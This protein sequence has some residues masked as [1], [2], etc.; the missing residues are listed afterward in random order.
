MGS[1][2]GGL[3]SVTQSPIVQASPAYQ[4]GSIL[5]GGSLG[6]ALGPM[7]GQSGG[8]GGT[9]LP[10]PQAAQIQPGV[11]PDQLGQGYVGAQQGLNAQQNLLQA[12]QAQNGIGNQSSVFNQSQ[13]LAN[14]LSGA[15]PV[16]T[17]QALMGQY[18]NIAAGG[19]PN[20]A[21]AML[22]QQTGQNVAN[23]GALMAGQRGA[24]ANVGLMARQAA[25]QG[26]STQ[27]Q[28]VGQAAQMQAQQQLAAM[29]AMSGLSGQQLS[30]LQAQ[31]GA[32]AGQAAGQV[33]NLAGATTGYSQGQQAEQQNLLN[34][35]AAQ[36][37]AQVG[38]Q[39]NVNSNNAQIS[40]QYIGQQGKILGGVANAVSGAA[41]LAEGG[42]VGDSDSGTDATPP[43]PMVTP[44]SPVIGSQS[45]FGRFLQGWN[46]APTG[47]PAPMAS[48]G[49]ANGGGHVSPKKSAQ[50]AEKSG[51]SYDNDKIPAMLSE[52]E[53]VLPR[54]VTQSGN[55]SESA[56]RFVQ[57][58]MAKK[59]KR[60]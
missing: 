48:G 24:G 18:A 47:T 25:Q 5:G 30:A 20:P 14:Q 36:N 3:G 4:I 34:A 52:G 21:M 15:N 38:S 55:P 31:Q 33:N 23:Q 45:S 29:Q 27:Q 42:E 12:L 1:A 40:G 43:T 50:K 54:S 58:L 16:A 53:I 7:F 8:L 10:A 32:L 46:S 56:A 39:G 9:G 17:Q 6:S 26:A 57:A 37:Q 13:G 51:D 59:G 41:G 44:P 2:A 22:N 49:L 19:G 35:N 60:A 28:A 11:T